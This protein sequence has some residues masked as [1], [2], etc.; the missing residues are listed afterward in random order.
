MRRDRLLVSFLLGSGSP[1]SRLAP[2][3]PP[4]LLHQ[5]QHQRRRG[6]AAAGATPPAA[7]SSSSLI[8]ETLATM[9]EEA[10]A[11]P[12]GA[13]TAAAL[14]ALGR[15][16]L[17][18]EERKR[19]RRALDGLGI[20][21]FAAFLK[22]RGLPALTRAPLTT[23]QLNIGLYCNQACNHCHVE[24]SPKR[25]R[26]QMDRAT[27]D[28]CLD[29]LRRSQPTMRTLDLTG[30]APEL[31][32]Q[33]RHLV[34]QAAPL[35]VEIMDRC[36]LTV[37]EEPGQEDL[38]AFLAQHRV[39]VVAS[40][41]CYEEKNVKLQRGSSVYQRSIAGLRKLNAV[42]YGQPGSGLQLTLVY[43]PVG[44]FLPPAQPAL[45]AKYKE[46]LAARFGIAFT[47]LICITN[48][49]IK[50]FADA[51]HR[52]GKLQEYMQLLVNSFNPQAMDGLMCR[53]HLSVGWDG[54]LYDCDFN[55]Q[56]DMA[57]PGGRGTAEGKGLTIFD[58]ADAADI[59]A[60][61]ILLDNHCFGC[62]AGEGS[63]CGG[64]T[65]AV[66]AAE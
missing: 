29:F 61:P 60:R 34:E 24:S 11:A 31:N 25:T 3:L 51:L 26:E 7:S 19:R 55:Q 45:E 50:R 6:L 17:S 40:L 44:A 1:H 42:G 59:A 43:N 9:E 2:A 18:L 21:P 32:A 22:E 28:R 56:L 52:A 36:N 35:G 46:E 62:T 48:M 23:L 47:D 20:K 4:L 8:P 5:H 57:L 49:P 12:P 53:S 16:R 58:V 15:G 33:F 39:R 14:R 54:R 41:P 10:K 30:G 64:A 63:S 38:P 27:A 37:L 13:P 66:A 65:A